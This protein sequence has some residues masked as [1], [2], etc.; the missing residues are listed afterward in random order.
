MVFPYEKILIMFTLFKYVDSVY[1]IC[2]VF[3]MSVEVNRAQGIEVQEDGKVV[4]KSNSS[5]DSVHK[6]TG[7]LEF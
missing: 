3:F 1:I 2:F 7:K 4:K 5:K 6:D